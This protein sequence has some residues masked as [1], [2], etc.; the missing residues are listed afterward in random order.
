M[1]T[2]HPPNDYGRGVPFRLII[3]PPN[4]Y[5]RGVPLRHWTPNHWRAQAR[6]SNFKGGVGSQGVGVKGKGVQGER[7]F[8][9]SG[10]SSGVGVQEEWVSL[11]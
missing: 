7:E 10:S 3:T 1:P 6:R 8:K 9:W 2:S 5:G 11:V 4:D